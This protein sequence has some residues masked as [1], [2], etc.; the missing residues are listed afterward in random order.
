[1]KIHK[2]I[3]WVPTSILVLGFIGGG[4]VDLLKLPDKVEEITTL[5]Y[6][7]Y[8]MTLLGIWKLLAGV[9]LGLPRL[10]QLK[11]WAYAGLVFDLTGASYSH[12]SSGSSADKVAVPLVFLAL[13]IL[14]WATRPESRK[15]K[16]T[17]VM[18]SRNP[19]PDAARVPA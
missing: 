7:V 16:G 1:M 4:A 6:P 13:T 5:G 19:E 18:M 9:T 8:L 15:L 2:Y 12:I 11:E 3:Y 14:S 10:P 17:F